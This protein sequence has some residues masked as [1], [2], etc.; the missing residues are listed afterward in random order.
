MPLTRLNVFV[1]SWRRWWLEPET[2]R[3]SASTTETQSPSKTLP[4][5]R[6]LSSYGLRLSLVRQ[7]E[8][9]FKVVVEMQPDLADDIH[10]IIDFPAGPK[11]VESAEVSSGAE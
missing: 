11:E 3:T 6:P 5:P 10:Y 4:P 1:T 9:W 8:G 7:D 2:P